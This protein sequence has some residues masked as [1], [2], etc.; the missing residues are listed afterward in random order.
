MGID[1]LSMWAP[2]PVEMVVIGFV[3]ILLFGNRLPKMIST[4]GKSIGEFRKGLTE[5][6]DSDEEA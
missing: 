6:D 2:G 1:V 3:A 5:R 4:M